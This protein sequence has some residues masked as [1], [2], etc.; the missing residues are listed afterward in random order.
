ML[1]CLKYYLDMIEHNNLAKETSF[2]II[3]VFLICNFQG[4]VIKIPKL[5]SDYF[6][7]VVNYCAFLFLYQNINCTFNCQECVGKRNILTT[8]YPLQDTVVDFWTMVYDTDSTVV[9]VLELLNEVCQP[10]VGLLYRTKSSF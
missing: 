9:V 6:Y 1:N 5:I 8:Q 7:L 4:R 10:I 2:N 3:F